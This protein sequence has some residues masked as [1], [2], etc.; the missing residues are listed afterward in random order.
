ML[1][2]CVFCDK[3]LNLSTENVLV[4]KQIRLLL[5]LTIALTQWRKKL[6]I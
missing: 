1:K 6:K 3:K 5:P 4:F 2:F